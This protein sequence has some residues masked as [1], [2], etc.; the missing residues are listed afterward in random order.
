MVECHLLASLIKIRS[1]RV[2]AHLTDELEISPADLISPW[3][4]RC[5]VGS[6]GDLEATARVWDCLVFEGPKVLHR[7][8]LALLA[9]SESTVFSCAHPQALPRLLEARCAQALCGPG[10]GGAL[11]GAAYKRSVVGGLPASLVAGLRAAA[12]E[13]VAGKLDE[14]RRRLAALLA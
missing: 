7:V 5:F 10:R 11:V 3:I 12:A 8:G 14:R 9:L 2:H 13:E 1:P 4:S 6:L